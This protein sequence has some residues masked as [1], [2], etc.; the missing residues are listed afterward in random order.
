V[1]GSPGGSR[2][3]FTRVHVRDSSLD[4]IRL[5]VLDA[6]PEAGLILERSVKN[7]IGVTVGVHVMS[8]RTVERSVG[9]MRRIIDNR[10]AR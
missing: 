5:V 10:P 1:V 3:C 8:P 7:S 6:A 2:G 4:H 9:K